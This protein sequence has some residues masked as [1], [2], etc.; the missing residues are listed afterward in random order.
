ML[1]RSEPPITGV[2]LDGTAGN[3]TILDGAGSYAQAMGPL[4]FIPS[5]WQRWGVD[6]HGSGR[7]D[8]N[9]IDDAAVTAG[10]YLCAAGGDLATG[11]GWR[12]GVLAYNASDDYARRVYAAADAYAHGT[13]A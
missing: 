9:N 12:A 4:Q 8:A 11:P 10:R 5:T 7:A 6:T 13:S 2:P 3:A 1:F